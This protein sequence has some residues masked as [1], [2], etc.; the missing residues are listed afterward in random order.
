M[1]KSRQEL[2]TEIATAAMQG[3]L[4]NSDPEAVGMN[5]S[6]VALYAVHHADALLKELFNEGPYNCPSC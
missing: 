5:S 2:R 4:A 3:I 6:D 1:S